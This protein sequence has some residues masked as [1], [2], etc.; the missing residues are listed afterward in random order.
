M[1]PSGKLSIRLESIG[2]IGGFTGSCTLPCY[3]DA[4]RSASI[5]LKTKAASFW[6]GGSEP[7][8]ATLGWRAGVPASRKQKLLLVQQ[9][10]FGLFRV[11]WAVEEFVVF[12]EDLDEGG[13]RSDGALD[14]RLR[15]R[16]FDVFLQRAA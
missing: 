1:S 15:Q 8:R 10:A 13:A 2:K 14:Q 3:T 12:Q 5:G 6:A 7:R 4:L 11:Y 16:V 9:D